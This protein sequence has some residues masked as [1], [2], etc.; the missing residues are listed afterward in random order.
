MTLSGCQMQWCVPINVHCVPVDCVLKEGLND[1]VFTFLFLLL[2]LNDLALF[3][4][5]IS[6]TNWLLH[7]HALPWQLL[8]NEQ[9]TDLGVAA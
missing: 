9:L 7:D 8:L 1:L 2:L 5:P 4:V 3:T 6:L